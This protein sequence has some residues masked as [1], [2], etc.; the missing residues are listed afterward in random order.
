MTNVI[1]IKYSL[2]LL[3]ALRVCCSSV[4]PWSCAGTPLL[5]SGCPRSS[6]SCWKARPREEV[7]DEDE[8]EASGRKQSW[9]V[10]AQ[11]ERVQNLKNKNSL[12]ITT[13]EKIN[14]LEG[15]LVQK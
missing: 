12:F 2:F 1:V 6:F 3:S 4:V 8:K 10:E 15:T 7:E 11:G 13:I 14:I 5:E 9:E